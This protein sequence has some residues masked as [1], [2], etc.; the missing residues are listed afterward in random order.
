[1]FHEIL[2]KLNSQFK[3]HNNTCDST[4]DISFCKNDV[5]MTCIDDFIKIY[6]II[7]RGAKFFN[8]KKSKEK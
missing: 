7:I 2:K 4:Y 1:M 3:L 5:A 6:I 8:Y